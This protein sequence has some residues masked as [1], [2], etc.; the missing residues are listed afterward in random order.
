MPSR[1]QAC[2]VPTA[3]ER[4]SLMSATAT[5]EAELRVVPLPRLP[6][7][8]PQHPDLAGLDRAALL[9]DRRP[10]IHRGHVG[11]EAL[12]LDRNDRAAG[13]AGAELPV[14]V[15]AP[16]DG[17]RLAGRPAAAALAHQADRARAVAR[18]SAGA[19]TVVEVSLPSW[20][21]ALAPQQ[22][23]VPSL[24]TAQAWPP[25]LAPRRMRRR[26]PGRPPAAA[27]WRWRRL[28]RPTGRPRCFPSTGRCR[29]RAQATS[30]PAEMPATPPSR[31]FTAT[32]AADR[33]VVPV[34]ELSVGVRT[35]AA[36]RTG[37]GEGAAE[38]AAHGHLHGVGQ[39][40]HL[41]GC[42]RRHAGSARPELA[43]GVG[44]PAADGPVTGHG[45]GVE[46]AGGD[47]GG[48]RP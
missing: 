2:E 47:V 31:P 23:A 26:T 4:A 15:G 43:E 38:V 37:L 11:R 13:R 35:P 27:R 45:A 36:H 21:A 32:G 42:R 20:P 1:A 34:P 9:A 48:V 30:L 12:D 7:V 5:G 19:G 24:V 41:D 39:A 14:G 46:G 40:L 3:I 8:V 25:T 29:R 22:W 44:A 10:G 28:R 17:A 33:F 16:T 6:V 18:T